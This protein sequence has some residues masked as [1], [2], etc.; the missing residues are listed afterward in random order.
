MIILVNMAVYH[1]SEETMCGGEGYLQVGLRGAGLVLSCSAGGARRGREEAGLGREDLFSG[2][3][4]V[5]S[6]HTQHTV[7]V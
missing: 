5:P 7:H 2:V 4:Q 6:C 3:R 1:L